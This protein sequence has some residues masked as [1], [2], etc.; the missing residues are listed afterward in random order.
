[1][2]LPPDLP[3]DKV[4]DFWKENR[5]Y[6]KKMKKKYRKSKSKSS[7]VIGTNNYVADAEHNDTAQ[8][9]IMDTEADT[10]GIE[11]LD[12]DDEDNNVV[13]E[14]TVI[15]NVRNGTIKQ[16]DDD[17][18]FRVTATRVGKKQSITSPEAERCFGGVLNDVTN[19]KVDLSNYTMEVLL[20]LGIDSL[21]I[22]VKLTEVSLHHRNIT[23]FGITTLRSTIAFNM[24]MMC[25]VQ[26]GDIVIDPMCGCGAIPIEGTSE[27]KSSYFLAGDNAHPAVVR[28]ISNVNYLNKKSVLHPVDVLKWDATNLPLK[29]G[30][31]DVFV[32]A[33]PFGKRVGSQTDNRELYPAVLKEL[34]RVSKL[35]SAR[36]CLLT[37]DKRSIIKALST[38]AQ[39][40]KVKHSMF[41]NIGGLKAAVHLLQRTGVPYLSEDAG[42][43][44]EKESEP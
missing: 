9:A 38:V 7:K 12:Q 25:A 13:S 42:G 19:W 15:D 11:T 6:S 18:S 40:W 8:D 10:N 33:L 39:M 44:T 31:V 41:I 20:T 36:A 27:W 4:V 28:S 30:T 17:L 21:M 35:S 5:K 14:K 43:G 34:A 1:M 3:W 29:T 2:K 32:T 22:A 23:H 37:Y 24:V 16:N 26:P